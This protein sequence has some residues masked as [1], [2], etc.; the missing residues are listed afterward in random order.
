MVI[1]FGN[2]I[3][4]CKP[5]ILF[6]IQRITKTASCKTF[7][8]CIDIVHSLDNTC[9]IKI[10]DQLS[11]LCS[12]RCCVDQFCLSRSRN[13]HLGSFIY[14]PISMTGNRDR[15]LPVLYTW[16]NSFYHDRSTKYRSIQN[17][18]DCSVRTLPHLF[19]FIFF[20]P[21][22]IRCNGR[23]FDCYFVL[24]CCISRINCNLV[25]CLIAVFQSKIIIICLKIDI[26]QKKIIF[27]HPPENSGHLIS[28]HLNNRCRHL[29][30]THNFVSFLAI[31]LRYAGSP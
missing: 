26:R 3:F 7:N 17:R 30:F 2:G 25:I 22:R 29:N 6:C 24:L 14:I 16:F 13:L 5:K 23:T 27:Y 10:M 1:F 15:L 20:Y 18:T 19:E 8:R 31:L 9:S 21:C 28:V 11:C 4:C 12:V